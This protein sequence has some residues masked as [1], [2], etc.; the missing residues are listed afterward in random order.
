MLG[1]FTNSNNQ[2]ATIMQQE[3]NIFEVEL[4]NYLGTS[5]HEIST[6]N[7]D[8]LTSYD[9]VQREECY[10]DVE[11]EDVMQLVMDLLEL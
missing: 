3:D 6:L 10:T 4:Y 8:Y 11:S 9:L 2:I 1:L 5:P 7:W